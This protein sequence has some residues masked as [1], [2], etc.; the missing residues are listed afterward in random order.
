MP[1][2]GALEEPVSGEETGSFLIKRPDFTPIEVL[3][4]QNYAIKSSRKLSRFLR[5]TG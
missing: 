2:L 3:A 5:K 4:R 1:M